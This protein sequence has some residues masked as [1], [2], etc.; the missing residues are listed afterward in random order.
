[1]GSSCHASLVLVQKELLVP[2]D[3]VYIGEE[4]EVWHH[5][6]SSGARK[7]LIFHVI[8]ALQRELERLTEPETFLEFGD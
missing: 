6:L 7:T 5:S 8:F 4:K 2:R 3:V 1:M